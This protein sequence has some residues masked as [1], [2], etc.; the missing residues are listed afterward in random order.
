MHT[1]PLYPTRERETIRKKA[2]EARPRLLAAVKRG[3]RSLPMA[4]GFFLLSLAQCF[5]VPSPYALC[6][7]AVMLQARL[8]TAGAVTGLI[9]GLLFRVVWGLPADVWQFA[10]CA[11]CSFFM[12]MKGLK[13]KGQLLL[14]AAL[15]ALRTLPAIAAATQMQTVILYVAGMA[16]GIGMTPALRRAALC[17]KSKKKE[18]SEDDLLCL[19]LPGLLLTAGA[20]R[21][22]AFDV[23]LG[24]IAAS[25]VVSALAWCAGCAVGIGAGLGCGLALLLCGQGA[26]TLVALTF[27]ALV[28]GCLQGKNR[29]LTALCFMLAGCVVMYLSMLRFV[30]PSMLALIIGAAGFAAMPRKLI[31]QCARQVRALR[32][33][34]P[35]ENAYTRLKMQRWVLAIDRMADALP[36][37]QPEPIDPDEESEALTESLCEGCDR[38]PICWHE[39]YVKMKEGVVALAMRPTDEEE[40]LSLINQYFSACPRIAR[41]PEILTKLDRERQKKTQ[42]VLCADYERGMIQTHLTALSQ[43]AQRMSLEGMMTDGEEAY[44]LSQVEDALQEARFPGH[45]VFV[46]KTDGRLIICLQCEALSLRPRTQA[47]LADRI[48]LRLNARLRITEEKNGRIILEEEPP[49]AIETGMAT[50]CAVTRERRQ[51]VGCPL[52]NGDAVLARGLS[53]GRML[54]ALSDGMGHGASAQNESKKTLEL[55]SLCMEAGYTRTQAMNA[56]NG[57][58]LSA[59]GGEKFAT[60][61]LCMV[62]LWTGEGA[63]NKLGAC[64]TMLFQGQKIKVIEGAALPLGIIE[65][66]VPMEHRFTMEENDVLIMMSDGITDAFSAEEEILAVLRRSMDDTPQHIADALLQ[67]AI[68]QKDGLPPDDMTVL[69]ARLVRRHPERRARPDREEAGA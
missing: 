65:H 60:V 21:L 37:P 54:L 30:W 9:A 23:N 44:R 52:D 62:D 66:V 58:M 5:S 38:L 40:T 43:A 28:A 1:L 61:D 35:R 11:A 12:R 10:A 19:M 42:K 47:Q 13:P 64:A 53:G 50:A 15:L 34:Q 14:T 3:A 26:L 18:W 32:W 48:G 69:C 8:P 39:E 33:T 27:S 36:K 63:M 16:L 46:K 51:R 22:Q 24:F 7:L 67:E 4:G 56:V 45:A 68:I 6:S 25:L 57:M 59:T 31:N 29:L 17:V 49:M 41:I 2:R 55:L 20:G